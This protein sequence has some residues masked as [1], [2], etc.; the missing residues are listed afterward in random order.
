MVVPLRTE[1]YVPERL[2]VDRRRRDPNAKSGITKAGQAAPV[3]VA[4]PYTVVGLLLPAAPLALPDD[5]ELAASEPLEALC[6]TE[7][8]PAVE[9]VLFECEPELPEVP[10]PEVAEVP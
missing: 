1:D 6:P 5:S 2:R 4:Q 9:P 3:P 7:E 8:P 10:E